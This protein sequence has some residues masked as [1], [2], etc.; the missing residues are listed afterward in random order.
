MLL[1]TD[2]VYAGDELPILE[3]VRTLEVEEHVRSA[4]SQGNAR[5]VLGLDPTA[6]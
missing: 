3:W 6:K 1:G 4:I 2:I 5:R